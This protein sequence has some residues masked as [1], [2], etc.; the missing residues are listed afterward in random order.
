MLEEAERGEGIEL[1][2]KKYQGA[3][4]F[5]K[6]MEQQSGRQYFPSDA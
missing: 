1:E 6:C 4:L 2:R 5:G 3:C